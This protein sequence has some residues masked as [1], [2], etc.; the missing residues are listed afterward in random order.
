MR[1]YTKIEAWKRSDDLTVAIYE[2]TRT[3]PKDSHYQA[4]SEQVKVTFRCL[5][6]LIQAVERESTKLAKG[7]AILTSAL[8]LPLGRLTTL[9]AQ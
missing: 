5:H 6:G 4:L 2:R 1:D 3:F 7:A 8:I 9:F